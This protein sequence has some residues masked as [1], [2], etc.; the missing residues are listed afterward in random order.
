LRRHAKVFANASTSTGGRACD[1][2]GFEDVVLDTAS[3]LFAEKRIKHAVI[4]YTPHQF[5][6][7]GTDYTQFLSRLYDLGAVECFT[8]Q[9]FYDEMVK[10]RLQSDIYCKFDDKAFDTT[11]LHILNWSPRVSL[12]K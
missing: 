12:L 2:E 5:K 4:E 6:G 9:L 11:G 1:V 3:K 10:N 7:R 8:L